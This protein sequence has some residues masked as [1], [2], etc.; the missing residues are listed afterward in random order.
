MKVI[1]IGLFFDWFV[2]R[3]LVWAGRPILGLFPFVHLLGLTRFVWCLCV[4]SCGIF[5][6]ALFRLFGSVVA[7]SFLICG[8]GT[9]VCWRCLL[10]YNK[11]LLSGVLPWFAG[12][13]VASALFSPFLC[14]QGYL[15]VAY[16]SR[17]SSADVGGL[18][19]L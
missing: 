15:L 17:V 6:G 16:I 18:G 11:S 5:T 10:K 9:F 2:P 1:P 7:M 3:V 8:V 12:G 4:L 19:I 13:V 14:A